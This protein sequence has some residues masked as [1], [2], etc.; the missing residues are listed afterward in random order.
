MATLLG[1]PEL[2]SIGVPYSVTR[3]IL[4]MATTAL[5]RR[6]V[7][8]RKEA[9]F[10][11]QRQAAKFARLLGITPASLHDL[12][13]GKSKTLGGKSLLGYIRLGA[14]AQFIFDGKGKPML[15]NIEKTLRAQTLVSMMTELEDIDMETVERM[16]KAFIRAKP[17]PSE[18]DPFKLDPP[19]T[20]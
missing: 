8:V 20:D 14:N 12:E 10:G 15:K 6:L 19:S 3:M 9:G 1:T 18:N 16:V 7:Q 11:D 17:G 4:G 13:S 2:V 5:G